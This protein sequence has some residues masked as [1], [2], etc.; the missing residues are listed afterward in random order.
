[1]AMDIGRIG[2]EAYNQKLEQEYPIADLAMLPS[3]WEDLPPIIQDAWRTAG[4]AIIQHV[5]EEREDMLTP[6]SRI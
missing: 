4:V 1:M 6:L 2:Y 5:E 3:R